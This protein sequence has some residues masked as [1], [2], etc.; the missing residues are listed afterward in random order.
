MSES[1][2]EK[3]ERHV[4]V[5]GVPDG[6]VPLIGDNVDAD[7]LQHAGR[8]ALG[9]DRV[10]HLA[11]RP[12]ILPQHL[13]RDLAHPRLRPARRRGRR[14]REHIRVGE[15]HLAQVCVLAPPARN[16]R[17]AARRVL[18]V[19]E[20]SVD[21]RLLGRDYR[22]LFASCDGRPGRRGGEAVAGV[23]NVLGL[24]LVPDGRR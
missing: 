20:V 13:V 21:E 9:D 14:K 2:R 22:Q 8:A 17:L 24:A 15:R 18:T 10:K 5:V 19:R 4:L 1:V 7:A 23:T 6:R 3:H 11:L 16:L 12:C